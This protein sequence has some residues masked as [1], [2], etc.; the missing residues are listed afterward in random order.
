[1]Q[2]III[3]VLVGWFPE[4]WSTS[5]IRM[6]IEQKVWLEKYS[7]KNVFM[8]STFDPTWNSYK[9]MYHHTQSYTIYLYMD[10][11]IYCGMKREETML[12]DSTIQAPPEVIR[13]CICEG[14]L[15]LTNR[16]SFGA[17]KCISICLGANS[18]VRAYVEE[19]MFHMRMNV[20]S[21]LVS[22]TEDLPASSIIWSLEN[23]FTAYVLGSQ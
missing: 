22:K 7:G 20:R 13:K 1:M 3:D 8:S 23:N 4:K 5:T 2:C 9:I 21:Q 16:V 10:Y 14:L 17:K 11:N 6:K 15:C 18:C 19:I 12:H